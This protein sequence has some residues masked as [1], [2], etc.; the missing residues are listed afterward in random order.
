MRDENNFIPIEELPENKDKEAKA[1]S[2][3]ARISANMV[4]FPGFLPDWERALTEMLNF[5]A[6]VHDDF[7]DALAKLG[8]GLSKMT[9]A[10]VKSVEWDGIVKPQRLTCGWVQRSH[11]IRE[12]VERYAS[13]D[14]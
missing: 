11:K 6:G 13:I 4:M 10:S 5:P 3:K 7:V 9:S 2:I 1:Q 14:N 8:Q 12:N